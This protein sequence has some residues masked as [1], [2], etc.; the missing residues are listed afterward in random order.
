VAAAGSLGQDEGKGPDMT[1]RRALLTT[2]LLLAG[3]VSTGPPGPL[4]P[5]VVG[6]EQH[7]ALD[8]RADPRDAA[9]V[10]VWG[11]A[12]NTSP[13]TFDRLRLLVE[14]FGP[15]GELVNQ[16]LVWAPGLLPSWGRLYFEAPMPPASA[17]RVRVFS[18]DRVE[19]GFRRDRLW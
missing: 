7:L 9:N 17:Y 1:W 16:R 18:Y 3:C 8:W 2:V 5:L 11:Y 13:Y 4:E 10:V 6:A 19:G 14:A 15:Q 12:A